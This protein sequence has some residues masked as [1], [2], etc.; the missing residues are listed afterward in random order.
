MLS[1]IHSHKLGRETEFSSSFSCSPTILLSK[2][3]PVIHLSLMRR[4]AKI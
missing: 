4:D 1:V 2:T 3:R